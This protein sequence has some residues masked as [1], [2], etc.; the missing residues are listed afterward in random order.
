VYHLTK[1]T[2]PRMPTGHRNHGIMQS[3]NYNNERPRKNK[4]QSSRDHSNEE[5]KKEIICWKC[6]KKGHKM[7][8]CRVKDVKKSNFHAHQWEEDHDD[9]IDE[10]LRE[11]DQYDEEVKEQVI[12]RTNLM[13]KR[14][15]SEEVDFTDHPEIILDNGAQISMFRD[16]SLLEDVHE[17]TTRVHIKGVSNDE[18]GIRSNRIGYLRGLKRLKIF[19]S[20]NSSTNIISLG[21]LIQS[22]YVI[23]WNPESKIF[24]VVND[25]NIRISF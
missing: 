12:E 21:E 23:R 9:I 18:E 3:I 16:E 24:I 22:D 15:I 13:M 2:N 4:V 11:M 25:D 19:V 5:L 20:P 6:H 8:E 14:I 10:F 7:K 17:S 1:N